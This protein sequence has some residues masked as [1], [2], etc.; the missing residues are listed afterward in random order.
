MSQSLKVF[1][2]KILIL[3]LFIYLYFWL[4]VP[5]VVEALDME[6]WMIVLWLII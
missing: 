6:T 4:K 1:N 5:V 3:L 2:G